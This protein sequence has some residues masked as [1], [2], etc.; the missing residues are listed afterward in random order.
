MILESTLLSKQ[1]IDTNRII[2]KIKGPKKGPTVI[3]FAGIHGNET[4]GVKALT[5]VFDT[6][7]KEDV[8]GVI[9]AIKGNL[10]AL[11]SNQRFI[12]EDLNRLWTKKRL[13]D[14]ELK[15]QFHTEDYE[16]KDLLLLINTILKEDSGPFYFIDF[17]TTSSKTLPFITINDALIN[18]KFSKLFP[19]PIVLG[20]EEYLEGPLLSYINELGYV[21]LGFESGQH[22]DKEAIANSLSFI[23]LTLVFTNAIAIEKTMFPIYF[24]QLKT[25]SHGITDI[26]EV[27][28]LYEIKKGESFKMIDGF[29]SFQ[30]VKKKTALAVS[31]KKTIRSRF[32]A[33]IFMP[34][35]Q[36]KGKE[37]FFII[38]KINPFYLNLSSLLRTFRVDNLLILLPGISWENK[39]KETLIVNL[40]TARFFA[41]SFFHLLGYRNK[42]VDASHIKLNN[43][44]RVAKQKM[45]EKEMWF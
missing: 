13:K 25:N 12:E 3:F 44:E 33:K 31:N 28:Y 17:H 37:G 41:K 42:Q 5:N 34:L 20:I 16:Q 43:R 29:K 10:K 7:G 32:N 14:L 22:K 24:E 8:K 23:Y 11:E 15:K 1:S 4:A 21:S 9:Y 30:N 36:K 26:F 27:V 38:K 6:L 19:V 18:R 40:K 35:Y 39:D 45:Y 2:G